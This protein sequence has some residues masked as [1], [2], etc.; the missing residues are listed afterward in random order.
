[1]VLPPHSVSVNLINRFFVWF[2][3][4]FPFI[5]E[6]DIRRSYDSARERRFSG[7][8]RSWLALLNA[9]FALSKNEGA[10]GEKPIVQNAADSRVFFERAHG[11]LTTLEPRSANIETGDN[12]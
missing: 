12:H 10:N 8:S 1:M 4:L 3:E 11:L 2:G 7:V 5:Y 6:G 9:I